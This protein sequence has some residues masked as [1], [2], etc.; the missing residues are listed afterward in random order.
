MAK[1]HCEAPCVKSRSQN[2]DLTSWK[3]CPKSFQV[4]ILETAS[5]KIQAPK[6]RSQV[7]KT[8]SWKP[9]PKISKAPKLRSQILKTMSWKPYP[10]I[11]QA[12][13]SAGPG[14][15]SLLWQTRPDTPTAG[16]WLIGSAGPG[17]VGL[18]WRTR[19]GTPIVVESAGPNPVGLNAELGNHRSF[20]RKLSEQK[21]RAWKPQIFWKKI[22]KTGRAKPDECETRA[23]SRTNWRSE[24]IYKIYT[25]LTFTHPMF[26]IYL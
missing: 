19:P 10:K 23:S 22:L 12:P 15:V 25:N 9:Y 14:P 3:S 8:M 17:P 21:I 20:E 11:S 6:L 7:L 16:D 13:K 24:F 18:L 5:V 1:G 26:Y 2:W 4:S